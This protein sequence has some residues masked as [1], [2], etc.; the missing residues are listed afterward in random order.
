MNPFEPEVR[1]AA[2]GELKALLA[3][4]GLELESQTKQFS[5]MTRLDFLIQFSGVSA[6]FVIVMTLLGS[7]WV[8]L[9]LVAMICGVL[10]GLRWIQVQGVLNAIDKIRD[11][12]K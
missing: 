10:V 9:F 5:F 4:I 2:S 7:P 8:G 1:R 3:K 12:L 6:I 11:I